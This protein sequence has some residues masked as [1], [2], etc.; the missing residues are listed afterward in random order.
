MGLVTL[1]VKVKVLSEDDLEV[2]QGMD[3]GTI[4]YKSERW[5]WR[6]Q[7]I[8]ECSIKNITQ[9]SASRTLVSLYDGK[10][11]LVDEKFE[12]VLKKWWEVFNSYDSTD[13]DNSQDENN[14]ED[15]D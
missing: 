2:Q 7:A 12:D 8:R 4:E 9:Y 14:S 10:S 5:A 13:E 6:N 15:D 1:R 3:L 11:L